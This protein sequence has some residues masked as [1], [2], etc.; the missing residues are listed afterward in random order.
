MKFVILALISM[1]AGSVAYAQVTTSSFAGHV[2]DADGAVAGA[3][4]IATHVPSGSNYYTVTDAD[5][6]YRIN[7]VTPGGPYNVIVD[8]L[9]YRKV[10]N[11]GIYATLGDVVTV[12]AVLEVESLGLDAAVFT[13]DGSNNT[14]MTRPGAGTSISQRTMQTLPTTSRS[15][16]DVLRLTPQASVTSNGLA[17]GGGNY[18]QSYVTVDGAAFNNAFGIGQNLPAGGAPIS[19]DAIEQM[20][21]NVTPYDVRM[22]GFTGGA[23]NAV[24]KSG[25][26]E[27]HASVYNYYNSNHVMGHKVSDKTIDN[28][29]SLDNTTGVTVGGPIVKNRL[30]FFVNFEYSL[31]TKP[32]STHVV[33]QNDAE[34][35][36]PKGNINR[37]TEAFMEEVLSFL[38]E[39]Y[40][41]N[42]GR[43]QGYSLSTPDWKVMARIDWNINDN[44]KF[45]VRFSKTM[46]K[47]SAAPSSSVNP[48]SPAPYDRDNYGRLSNFAHYFE[49]S[50]YYQQQNFT[51]LAA[52]LNSRLLDGRLNN[53]FRLTWSHQNEP[54]SFVGDNFPTVDIL[55]PT[56]IDASG[57]AIVD[58]D[59]N[60]STANALLTSF[61]LDPF[62]YGNL[63]DVHTVVATDEVSVRNGIHNFTAGVQFEWNDTKNGYMQGGLGY[64]VYDSWDDFKAAGVPAAF[65]ITHPNRDDLQQVYPAFQY[66][67]AS[68]Y[69]QDEVNFSDRFKLTAG[70][71]FELPIYPNIAGNE[72]KEFTSL[73]TKG[74]TLYGLKTSDMPASVASISPRIGFNWD[75]FGNRAVVLRGGAGIYTGR[76]PFVWIV[77]AVGNSNCLQKQYI[78]SNGTGD[79]TPSFHSNLN[80]I[81]SDMYGGTFKAGDIAAPIGTTILDKNLVM[82]T[83]LK[84]SLAAD[85]RLPGGILASIEGIYNK[86]FSEVYVNKLGQKE[87]GIGVK[88]D[89]EP[90]ARP[91]VISEKILNSEGKTINPYY[92]YNVDDPSKLGYYYSVTA[93]LQKDFNFGLSLMAA[94]TRSGNKTLSDGIG[95]QISS[96]YNTMTYNV[97]GSHTPELG[98]GTYVSPNRV[99]ANVSYRIPEG[100]YFAT[101]IGVFYEGYNFGYVGNSY[102]YT[103]YSYTVAEKSGKYYNSLT[104]DGGAASLVY[105]PTDAQV[106]EMTFT[107]EEN[108]AAFKAFLA[109]DKY[110]SS[111]RGQY[112]ERGA[113]VMPWNNR[114]NVKVAQDFMFY[115]GKKVHTITLGVDIN[116]I[117]NLFNKSWG[118][119]QKL[120]S[121]RIL[122]VEGGKYTFSEPTW[123][124]L[125]STISTW[126]MMFTARYSF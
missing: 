100:R 91:K 39:K 125:V 90:S 111:H 26:N 27:W 25:T 22:S 38:S 75:L 29:I 7:A 43:Y 2:S 74:T 8:M 12:N 35:F 50:R 116:N 123:S 53:L 81:L 54:R 18:R 41:Y 89:G 65:A 117:G 106:A 1:I 101:N 86:N 66:M 46:N 73:A 13:A 15:M 5:G 68:W 3:P 92:I 55:M 48:I 49:S 10:E 63:R 60:P 114:I 85:F 71:R 45:N 120:S 103:R 14:S 30:F 105:I 44:H 11:T 9:G 110:L 112:S 107:S 96:A 80:D 87:D 83:T 34:S 4:V 95:D 24:T 121:D 17:I 57:N 59:G 122:H 42:P 108:K 109:S 97:N 76:I 64:Y 62:T 115:T 126:N 6:N 98:Y 47:Y 58:S 102:S 124:P 36:S 113:L 56:S 104:G 69:A 88:W 20:S 78:D 77:S 79:Y 16:N 37:P 94:Y 33:R 61:G 19:L 52:E 119:V 118:N 82:P 21:V 28:D 32:G 23:I 51:S 31:D 99:V 67:Q 70:V 72:N 84:T 40:N 93:T